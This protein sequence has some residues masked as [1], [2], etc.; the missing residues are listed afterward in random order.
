MNEGWGVVGGLV[1]I[2]GPFV[3]AVFILKKLDAAAKRRKQSGGETRSRFMIVDLLS[4]V[5]LLQVPFNFLDI[6]YVEA[7]TVVLTAIF[8][9]A[10]FLVWLTTIKTVSE[11]GI[12]SFGWRALISMILIPT[13]YI[14]SF[15][16]GVGSL[17]L[18]SGEASPTWRNCCS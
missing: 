2:L 18:I 9:M 17:G 6:K 16:F 15:Y 8:L 11:A 14:G 3:Y 1:L 7:T 13:M 4:L 12:T 5:L 10:L